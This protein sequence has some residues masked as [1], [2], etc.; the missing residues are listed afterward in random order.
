[1]SMHVEL[2][3]IVETQ[4]CVLS[5]RYKVSGSRVLALGLFAP[6]ACCP[7]ALAFSLLSFLSFDASICSWVLL[8]RPRV[9]CLSRS[10]SDSSITAGDL[11]S[12]SLLLRPHDPAIMTPQCDN[13]DNAT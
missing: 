13:D 11:I 8:A 10:Q 3:Q 4:V 5:Y 9:L 6:R 12:V 1:M 2:A 7:R